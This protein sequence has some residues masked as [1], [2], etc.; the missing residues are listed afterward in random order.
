MDKP[1]AEELDEEERSTPLGFYNYAEAYWSAAAQLLSADLK[2]THR[3]APIRFLYYHAIELYLKSFLRFNSVRARDLRGRK[4]GHD[5]GVL[6][7][8]A[9]KLGLFFE[10]EDKEIFSLMAS[11]DAQLRSRYLQIGFFNWPTIEGLERTCRSLRLSVGEALRSG[12]IPIR[13]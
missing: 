1:I 12:G 9:A 2:S 5:V 4:F 7:T 10:D 3:D 13:K 11:T 6:S 8:T